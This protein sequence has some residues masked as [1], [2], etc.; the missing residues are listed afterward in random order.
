MLGQHEFSRKA[1][2]R[3]V[4]DMPRRV[5]KYVPHCDLCQRVHNDRVVLVEECKAGGDPAL[6]R[7]CGNKKCGDHAASLEYSRSRS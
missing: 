7:I 1:E 4:S 2:S 6:L 5:E 3:L